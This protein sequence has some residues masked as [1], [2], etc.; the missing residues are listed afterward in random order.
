MS[1]LA[2]PIV[3]QMGDIANGHDEYLGK[4][5]MTMPQTMNGN[6][7]TEQGTAVTIKNTIGQELFKVKLISGIVHDRRRRRERGGSI[8]QLHP[9]IFDVSRYFYKRLVL[10]PY[11]M[12]WFSNLRF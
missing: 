2:A 12:Q 3:L 4:I 10:Y 8:A 6:F 11:S 1:K 5:E 9:V 7:A